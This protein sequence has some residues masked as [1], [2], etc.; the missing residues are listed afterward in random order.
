[1]DTHQILKVDILK[2]SFMRKNRS[3]TPYHGSTQIWGLVPGLGPIPSICLNFT[4]FYPIHPFFLPKKVKDRL[5]KLR[6]VLLP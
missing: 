4:Q 1:M 3:C 2:T 5:L 6:N